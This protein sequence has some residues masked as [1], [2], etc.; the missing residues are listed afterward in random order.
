LANHKRHRIVSTRKPQLHARVT[1]PPSS[2]FGSMAR[3]A[4]RHAVVSEKHLQSIWAMG[5]VPRLRGN[6]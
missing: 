4:L 1:A 2:V 6:G 5:K 3:S